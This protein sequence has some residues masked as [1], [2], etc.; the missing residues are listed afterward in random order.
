M[1]ELYPSA[2]TVWDSILDIPFEV[3]PVAQLHVNEFRAA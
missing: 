3:V 2:L 1:L